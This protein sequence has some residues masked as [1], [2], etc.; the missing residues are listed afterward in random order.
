MDKDTIHIKYNVVIF[1][2]EIWV[3]FKNRGCHYIR[4]ISLGRVII[5]GLTCVG[6]T[7]VI[8]ERLQWLIREG[9][10]GLV[11][12]DRENVLKFGD[13]SR[14][15]LYGGNKLNMT[16]PLGDTMQEGK[17]TLLSDGAQ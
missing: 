4:I 17:N 11:S 5:A 10:G 1:I 7:V 2:K 12:F 14:R 8:E 13:N 9:G 16:L 15:F 6:W 3:E